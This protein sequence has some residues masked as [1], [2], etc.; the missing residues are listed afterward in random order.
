MLSALTKLWALTEINE[1]LKQFVLFALTLEIQTMLII[2]LL[3]F[4]LTPEM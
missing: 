2:K 1:A 3:T 4:K